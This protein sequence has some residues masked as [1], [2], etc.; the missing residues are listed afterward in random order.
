MLRGKYHCFS[1]FLYYTAKQSWKNLKQTRSPNKKVYALDEIDNNNKSMIINAFEVLLDLGALIR[2][3]ICDWA[4]A[5][6]HSVHNCFL[7]TKK[8][9]PVDDIH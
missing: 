4:M 6:D 8:T 7:R 9:Y 5:A 1:H 3:T 2:M